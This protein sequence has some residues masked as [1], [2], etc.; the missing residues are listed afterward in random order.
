MVRYGKAR[1]GEPQNHHQ[2]KE[3]AMS[4]ATESGVRRLAARHNLQLSKVRGCKPYSDEPRYRVSDPYCSDVLLTSE[5]G[6]S[7]TEAR[8]LI[9]GAPQ[10]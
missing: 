1:R 6:I 8:D 2:P 7:L 3:H 4:A 5:Y 9:H 10:S